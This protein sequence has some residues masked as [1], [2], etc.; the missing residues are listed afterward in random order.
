MGENSQV[1]LLAMSLL[2]RCR[3]SL[4]MTHQEIHQNKDTFKLFSQ[5]RMV[6]MKDPNQCLA[7]WFAG[8]FVF[9]SN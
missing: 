1:Q 5:Q 7:K 6:G 8:F 2:N 3:V 9:P 4:Q